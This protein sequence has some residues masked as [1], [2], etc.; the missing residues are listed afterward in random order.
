M[1]NP[2]RKID[3]K[4]LDDFFS[5]LPCVNP[6]PELR[7]KPDTLKSLDGWVVLCGKSTDL[8]KPNCPYLD[9]SKTDNGA[10]YNSREGNT[11]HKF[12]AC[13]VL[14]YVREGI[15]QEADVHYKPAA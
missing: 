14:D 10:L 5:T 13:K 7:P 4:T 8:S 11:V 12:Y 15:K 1:G 3:D 9:M 2:F 6:N